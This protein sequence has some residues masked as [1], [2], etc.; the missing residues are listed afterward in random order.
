MANPIASGT[1]TK[2]NL[3]ALN[4]LR[5]SQGDGFSEA[6]PYAGS[7]VLIHTDTSYRVH[8]NPT[9]FAT[10]VEVWCP[11]TATGIYGWQLAVTYTAV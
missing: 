3:N 10:N 4:A 7:Q 5:S 11:D 9:T 2:A 6:S 1:F 8:Y